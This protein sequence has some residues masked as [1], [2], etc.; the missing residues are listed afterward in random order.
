[1]S[2]SLNIDKDALRVLLA[3]Q[4]QDVRKGICSIDEA[5]FILGIGLSDFKKEKKDPHTHIKPS[6]K[7]GK[8]IYSSIIKEFERIHGV[9]YKEAIAA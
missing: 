6:K 8:Y 7:Q 5:L 9:A 1:M 2:K 4:R 3:G